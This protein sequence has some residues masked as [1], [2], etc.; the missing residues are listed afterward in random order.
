MNFYIDVERSAGEYVILPI[1][2][3]ITW[4]KLDVNGGYRIRLQALLDTDG[5]YYD[6]IG[7]VTDNSVGMSDPEFAGYPGFE[8]DQVLTEVES[9]Q[10][11]NYAPT[12]ILLNVGTNDILHAYDLPNI[13]LRLDNFITYL[14]SC[15]PNAHIYVATIGPLGG[16]H[17]DLVTYDAHIMAISIPNVT[18]VDIASSVTLAMLSDSIHPNATGYD[19]HANAWHAALVP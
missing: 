2:D 5:I 7:P 16:S 19:V 10:I 12:A 9:F 1:G 14:L 11:S 3:S 18:P 8:I 13:N 6:F 17:P 4:G 15:Y